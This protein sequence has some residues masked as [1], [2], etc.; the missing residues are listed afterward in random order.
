M[1]SMQGKVIALTGGASGIGLATAKVL[2]SRGAILCLADNRAE[3]L[4]AAVKT[5]QGGG[6]VSTAVVDTRDRKQVDDWIA[7]VV[8]EHGRLDGAANLAGVIGPS[9]GKLHIADMDDPENKEWEFV[10][11]VNVTG[12]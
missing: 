12:V 7:G 10:M 4:A 2:S 1:A 5:I 3:P 11:G 8:K 6:K 9:M